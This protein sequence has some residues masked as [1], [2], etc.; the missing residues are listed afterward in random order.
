MDPSCPGKGEETRLTNEN[1]AH[2]VTPHEKPVQVMRK[3]APAT[4]CVKLWS[5][6]DTS[7]SLPRQG[8]RRKVRRAEVRAKRSVHTRNH[9][10]NAHTPT[11]RKLSPAPASYPAQTSQSAP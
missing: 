11:T 8:R 6:K 9:S 3:V 4:L 10:L 5:K 7:A 2:C 1:G